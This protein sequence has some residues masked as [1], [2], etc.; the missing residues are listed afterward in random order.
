M[1]VAAGKA[2]RGFYKSSH[3]YKRVRLSV[4]PFAKIANIVV[5][6]RVG[7]SVLAEEIQIR[8]HKRGARLGAV[9]CAVHVTGRER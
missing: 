4:T 2:C 9:A 3:H 1:G 6:L 5:I 7:S 8:R